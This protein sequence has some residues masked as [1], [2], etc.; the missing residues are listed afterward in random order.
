MK[1]QKMNDPLKNERRKL[2]SGLGVLSVVALVGGFN[3]FKKKNKEVIACNPHQ[4][5]KTVKM[6]T[7]D[8]R[9]VEID[10]SLLASNTKKISNKELQSWIKKK[11]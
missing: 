1:E 4:D 8:G 5:Q 11:S 9:L 3:L 2:L 6:L 7:Q 10:A